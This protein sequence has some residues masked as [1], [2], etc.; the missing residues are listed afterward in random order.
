MTDFLRLTRFAYR[1]GIVAC[2]IWPGFA[3]AEFAAVPEGSIRYEYN[4]NIFAVP[5]GDPLLVAQGDLQRSDTTSTL[6]GGVVFNGT[7]G[8]QKLTAKFEGREVYYGHYTQLNHSEYLGD[9]DFHWT[10]N[11]RLD[12]DFDVRRDHSMAA[13][14]DRETTQLEVDTTQD[15][16]AN[17][18]FKFASDFRLEA[19]FTN[20]DVETPLQGYPDAKVLENTQRLAVRYLGVSNLSFGIEGSRLEGRFSGSIDPS[21]YDQD[22]EDFVF[23]YAAGSFSKING[24]IGY[25]SRK[26]DISNVTTSGVTGAIG[27]SRQLTG[28][29]SINGEVRRAINIFVVG[30]GSEI[31]TSE[32]LGANWEATSHITVTGNVGHIHS[33]YG[34]QAVTDMVDEG[35]TDQYSFVSLS[36]S[37]QIFRWLSLRPYGRY[38]TRHSNKAEFTY[39]GSIVGVELR[40]Q[41]Q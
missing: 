37:Y 7:W 12:G 30:G 1:A 3:D 36:V 6:V 16:I 33:V 24:S 39:D 23:T 8:L 13:F 10:F 31:D 28:K 19:G 22:N 25:S 34:Q 41:Y 9:L 17:L 27:F 2:V 20:H 15:A 4:S 5:P 18:N 11:S 35:R 26:D 40:G 21:T 38:E 29:T 32:S 14:M